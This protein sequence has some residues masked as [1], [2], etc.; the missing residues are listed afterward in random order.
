MKSGSTESAYHYLAEHYKFPEDVEVTHFP[1]KLDSNYEP[2][3]AEI[4]NSYH[5]FME[6]KKDD[7]FLSEDKSFFFRANMIGYDIWLDTTIKLQHI[8]S[9]IFAE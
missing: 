2:T 4:D 5:F 9:H 1:D 7:G 8:G 3:Q 6:H